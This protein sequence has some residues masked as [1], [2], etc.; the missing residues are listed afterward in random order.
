[1][2]VR[3]LSGDSWQPRHSRCRDPAV[4]AGDT[5]SLAGRPAANPAGDPGRPTARAFHAPAGCSESGS[6]GATSWSSSW[7]RGRAR[8]AAG[9]FLYLHPPLRTNTS[10]P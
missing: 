9:H 1:M 4:P 8:P 6:G 10:L 2:A 7:S 5:A 3:W